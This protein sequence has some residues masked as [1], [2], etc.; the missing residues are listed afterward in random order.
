MDAEYGKR[1]RDL[2]QHHWWWRAREAALLETITALRPS[3]GWAGILDV[4]CGDG[5][6]F[7]QLR[8]FGDVEGVEFSADVVDP[9]GPHRHRIHVC[10]FDD[11]F[12]PGHQYDLILMLDVLE[13]LDNPVGALRRALELLAPPGLLIITVPAFMA[14]WTN[15]DVIN[16]HRTRYTR[17]T[18]R[19]VANAAG[20][21]IDQERYW[22]Q[23]M[24]PIKLAARV[25]ERLSG[26]EP[27]P[28][29]IPP[30]WL[31]RLLYRWSRVER[32]LLDPLRLPFGSSLLAIGGRRRA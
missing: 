4:G 7:D 21:R 30:R 3:S 8:S 29:D 10:P 32:Q 17:R 1:Y 22:F 13:H 18:F 6:F 2:Y 9:H 14:L 23:W 26:R 16:H 12:K 5:L 19:S 24:F 31:N 11:H 25:A 20:M 15:H 28:A 27:A